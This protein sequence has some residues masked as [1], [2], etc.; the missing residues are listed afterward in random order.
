MMNGSGNVLVAIPPKAVLSGR[1]ASAER[2]SADRF[3]MKQRSDAETG[4]HVFS[5]VLLHS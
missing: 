3:A 2:H 5:V 1:E 4:A